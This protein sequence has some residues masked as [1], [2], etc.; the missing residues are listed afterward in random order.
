MQSLHVLELG[1]TKVEKLT[2]KQKLRDFIMHSDIVG[3]IFW[4][5]WLWY[6]IRQATKERKI[7]EAEAAKRSPMTNDEY[8]EMVHRRKQND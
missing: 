1:K 4:K 8:W 3:P 5:L 6:G 2:F 7:R